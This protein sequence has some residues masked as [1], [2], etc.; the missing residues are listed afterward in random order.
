M[1]IAVRAT[2]AAPCQMFQ[3]NRSLAGIDDLVKTLDACV[4]VK[5]RASKASTVDHVL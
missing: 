4:H 3:C 2:S 5:V 1:Q